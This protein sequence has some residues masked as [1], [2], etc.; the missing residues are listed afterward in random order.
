MNQVYNVEES[1][2]IRDSEQLENL[3][4]EACDPETR[5][6]LRLAV[7]VNMWPCGHPAKPTLTVH[8]KSRE[9]TEAIGMRQGYI[10]SLLKQIIGCPAS[11]AVYYNISEGSV[12]FDTEGEVAPAKWY[13]CNRKDCGHMKIPLP[14]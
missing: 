12:Y 6:L 4:L 14:G 9:V 13:L 11:M 1:K 8:C 5:A 2:V 7:D 3:L 10:K